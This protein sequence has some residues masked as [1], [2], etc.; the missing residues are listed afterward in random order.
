MREVGDFL[1]QKLVP[2][3]PAKPLGKPLGDFTAAA[4]IF[5]FHCDDFEHTVSRSPFATSA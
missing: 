4:S 3:F 1:S 5:P 2:Q